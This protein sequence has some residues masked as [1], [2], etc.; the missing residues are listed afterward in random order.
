MEL[1]IVL[2]KQ[3]IVKLGNMTKIKK[4]LNLT[5]MMIFLEIPTKFSYNNSYYYKYF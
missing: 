3:M 1:K 2:T 4:I 5:Q